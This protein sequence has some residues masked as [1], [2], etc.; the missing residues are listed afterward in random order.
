VAPPIYVAPPTHV[1]TPPYVAPHTSVVPT[2]P[3]QGIAAGGL[4][5]SLQAAQL[6]PE[7]PTV[8]QEEAMSQGGSPVDFLDQATCDAILEG[9]RDQEGHIPDFT[10]SPPGNPPPNLPR[11]TTSRDGH[12]QTGACH[13]Q[14][15]KASNTHIDVADAATQV[16][17]RPH[18]WSTATQTA[19]IVT[20][21]HDQATQDHLRPPRRNMFT[22]TAHPGSSNVMTQTAR[23][24]SYHR[25]SQTTPPAPTVDSATSMAPVLV[26]TTGCQAGAFY[27]NDIIP[28]DVPRPRLPWAYTYEQ[29]EALLLAYPTVHPEDFV[30]FGVFQALP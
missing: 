16:I 29:F 11:E 4:P 20:E 13:S 8:P 7:A 21:S 3:R 30:T 14:R 9:L 19:T 18:L 17:S 27:T 6:W 23:P 1:A 12:T 10:D 24:G 26:A 5:A 25:A 15:E 22:Q 2:T 28:P